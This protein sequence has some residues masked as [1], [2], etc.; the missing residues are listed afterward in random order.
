MTGIVLASNEFELQPQTMVNF[1]H[2]S[3]M[4]GRKNLYQKFISRQAGGAAKMDFS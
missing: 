3:S 1:L 2:T 4:N